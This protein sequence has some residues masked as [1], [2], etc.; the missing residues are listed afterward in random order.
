MLRAFSPLSVG[1]FSSVTLQ[2]PP[3]LPAL[4]AIALL[5]SGALHAEE[6]AVTVQDVE[7]IEVRG[8]FRQTNLQKLPGSVVVLWRNRHQTPIRS[9]S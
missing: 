2:R 9:A 1:H 8:D 5:V 6:Q 4:S 7:R 3:F